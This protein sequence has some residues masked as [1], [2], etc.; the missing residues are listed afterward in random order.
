MSAVVASPAVVVALLI[1][2]CGEEEGVESD[3]EARVTWANAMAASRRPIAMMGRETR[4]MRRRPIMS[5]AEKASR[6]KRKLVE[7][8]RRETAVGESKPTRLNIVAEKYI[9]EFYKGARLATIW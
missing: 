4:R 9:N 8:M 2:V 3:G 1:A 6:V 5:M 7:A